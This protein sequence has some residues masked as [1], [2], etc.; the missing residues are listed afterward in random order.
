VG[1]GFHPELTGRENVYLNGTILGM[2]KAEIDS[3]FDEIVDFSGIEKF[4]DT[5]VKRYS[6]GMKVR[7]AFSV[8]AHLEP[9]ILIIDEVLAVG[10]ADFQKKCLGKMQEVATGE[11]RTVLFVSH[12][13]AAVQ[14][15]CPRAV[16]LSAGSLELDDSSSMAIEQ[17]LRRNASHERM[18]GRWEQ[19][20][21]GDSNAITS[22]VL[23]DG[24]GECNGMLLS[25]ATI[26]VEISYEHSAELTNPVFGIFVETPQGVRLFFLQSR[27]QHGDISSLPSSGKVMCRLGRLPLPAG[28]YCLSIVFRSASRQV[29]MLPQAV[30]FEVIEADFFGTGRLPKA[31]QGMLLVDAE[32][33]FG[34]E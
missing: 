4:L 16:L 13:M 32:W 17:Y 28:D 23:K 7:L 30:A 25:G 9:E 12:N 1:T 34:C 26:S 3:K 18:T 20:R 8:A 24:S 27:L 10:D 29:D 6:S 21:D 33:E 5:P 31:R 19:G 2:K 11:G 15:L 22:V 14:R